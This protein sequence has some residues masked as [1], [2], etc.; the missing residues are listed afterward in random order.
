MVEARFPP[1]ENGGN[2]NC[3]VKLRQLNED[4]PECLTYGEHFIES[5][6]FAFVNISFV[7][8]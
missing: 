7:S 4:L 5:T 1:L 8:P 6:S 3:L 2:N